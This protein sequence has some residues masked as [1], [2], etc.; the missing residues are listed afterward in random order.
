M[1][2]DFKFFVSMWNQA[3]GMTT[4]RLH[5]RM[6]HWL[7]KRW[8]DGDVNLLLMVFRSAGKST[9]VGLF[10][11]WLLYR[12]RDLRILVLAADQALAGKMVR[13]VKR[14]LERHPLCAGMKPERADQWASDR[15]TVA[16]DLE[17]RDPSMLARGVEAN[18]TG[19][20]A[21]IVICDDVEVPK[22]CDS[23]DKRQALRERLL[24]VAYVL[25][26]GGMQLYVGTPHHYYSLYADSA[27]EDIGE[28]AP[29]LDGFKRLKIP[30]LDA[31]GQS[32]WPERF[33]CDHICAM[34]AQSSRAKFESQMML[35][36]TNILDGR[37][38]PDLLQIYDDDL[39]YMRELRRLEIGA[40][41]MVS[42]SAYWD[43][44]FGKAGGDN[45]VVAIVFADEDGHRYI[46][47]VEY[48][49]I[50]TLADDDEA[51]QQC[52]V[53]VDLA[54][55]FYLPSITVETNGLGRFLPGLLRNALAK[56][57]CLALWLS[58]R[59]LRK[60]NC[61]Y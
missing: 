59:S 38:N 40:R 60:K 50:S 45:S 16:R 41:R 51:T 46:Q 56:A 37:L 35:R 29:F 9:I 31:Q 2:V 26:P 4:P 54:R 42:A 20:R 21:D 53:V 30:V 49:Q 6:A 47:H 1:K 32:A 10:C 15:F 28:E 55:R 39:L 44:A 48:I 36:P 58:A 57:A 34:Q 18:L 5:F 13:N 33:S 52:A 19:S 25:V 11:A 27:R 17:L 12:Q 43:P 3:Q 8:H 61:G 22:T 24:E 14:I 7:E 23:A